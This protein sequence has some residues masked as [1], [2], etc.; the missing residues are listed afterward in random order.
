MVGGPWS[1][2]D[3][4][5]FGAAPAGA[6]PA[7]PP[8]RPLAVLGLV[9]AAWIGPEAVRT[10]LLT[11]A[12]LLGAALAAGV[13]TPTMRPRSDT[14]SPPPLVLPTRLSDDELRDAIDAW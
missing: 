4:G 14:S 12:A 2:R 7:V 1:A 9:S 5:R 11:A 3:A 6:G 10:E 13:S 8:V